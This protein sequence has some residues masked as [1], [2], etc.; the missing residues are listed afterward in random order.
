[1]L[2]AGRRRRNQPAPPL[3]VFQALTE[4]HRDPQRH[5][6]ILLDDEIEP[7]VIKSHQPDYSI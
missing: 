3:A 5:W 1:V 6:L 2:E 4:P 7:T